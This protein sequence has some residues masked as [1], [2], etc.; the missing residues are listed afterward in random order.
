M[1]P[2]PSKKNRL[3]GLRWGWDHCI[4][5][6]LIMVW[7]CSV[8]LVNP[9]GDYPLMDDWVYGLVVRNI[10]E[11][12]QFRFISPASTNLFTQAYWG[13]LFCLPS[14]YSFVALRLSTIV[15][16]ALGIASLYSIIRE[17]GCSKILAALAALLLIFNPFYLSL[18]NSFMTDVPFTALL[19]ICLYAYTVALKHDSNIHLAAAFL[20]GLVALGIRQY[21]LIFMAGLCIGLLLKKGLG[22]RS[23]SLSAG[24][25]ISA[26][27]LQLLYQHWLQASGQTAGSDPVTASYFKGFNS[28]LNAQHLDKIVAIFIYIGAFTLPILFTYAAR[29]LAQRTPRL[30]HTLLALAV[31]IGL[32]GASILPHYQL[33]RFGNI[34]IH[35]GAGPLT[36]RDS[37]LLE[38]NYPAMNPWIFGLWTMLTNFGYLGLIIL[39][40]LLVQAIVMTGKQFRLHLPSPRQAPGTLSSQTENLPSTNAPYWLVAAISFSMIIYI[41]VLS[42]GHIFDRYLLPLYPAAMILACALLRCAPLVFHQTSLATLSTGRAAAGC[43]LIGLIGFYAYFSIASTH[44]YLAW[45]RARWKALQDLVVTKNISPRLIDGGYEFNGWYLADRNYSTKP[46]KSYWWVDRDDYMIASGPLKGFKEIARYPFQRWLPNEAKPI[47]TLKKDP[48]PSTQPTKQ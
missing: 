24:A 43:L 18:A 9:S 12:G 42:I 40:T 36:L 29:L 15:L 38:L 3:I 7:G 17:I 14:G 25:M 8:A 16:A 10:L 39:S 21:A 5:I 1:N 30:R 37:Y 20:L 46:D 13:A 27:G 19:M 48:I 32:A 41:I 33:P 26:A 31:C 47:L 22:W 28:L 2:P 6:L 34:L 35:S 4:I 44:D 45:T 11:T 23:L